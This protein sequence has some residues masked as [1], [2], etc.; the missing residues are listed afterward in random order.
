[1]TYMNVLYFVAL[2]L[3]AACVAAANA[4]SCRSRCWC[5]AVSSFASFNNVEELV[6]S[7][8]CADG[9]DDAS[10]DGVCS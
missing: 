9:F 10:C 2:K 8:A 7:D 4:F 3:V 1:M 6:E 5:C